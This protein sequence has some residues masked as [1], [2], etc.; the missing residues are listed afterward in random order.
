MVLSKTEDHSPCVCT[1]DLEKR[2]VCVCVGVCC[3][4]VSVNAVEVD[5]P[6]EPSGALVRGFEHRRA[7]PASAPTGPAENAADTRQE[8]P[9]GAGG[10]QGRGAESGVP[11]LLWALVSLS[12][13]RGTGCPNAVQGP[14]VAY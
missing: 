10:T 12:V 4:D 11:S 7:D 8:P 9:L 5:L 3:P 13:N 2:R 14:G 6:G 1:S